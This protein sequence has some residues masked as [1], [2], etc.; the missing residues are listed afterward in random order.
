M[1][2]INL[3]CERNFFSLPS[4]SGPCLTVIPSLT[5][6]MASLDLD[7]SSSTV[8]KLD[9]KFSVSAIFFCID[10]SNVS[11]KKS[12]FGTLVSF[13]NRDFD[14]LEIGI[15]L[16]CKQKLR[17]EV[18]DASAKVQSCLPTATETTVRFFLCSKGN[19]LSHI[20]FTFFPVISQTLMQIVTLKN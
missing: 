19:Y 20:N 12:E 7:L 6:L 1:S 3:T 16:E 11:I 13:E 5:V 8:C 17:K 14:F 2:I 18:T 9:W 4:F 10:E 15:F